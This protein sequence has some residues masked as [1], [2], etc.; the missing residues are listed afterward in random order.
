MKTPDDSGRNRHADSLSGVPLPHEAQPERWT[1][2]L[3][4]VN[5]VARVALASLDVNG[6]LL[7]RI[8]GKARACEFV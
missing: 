2:H 1:H 7:I 6:E 4:M 5:Q 8:L 3:A